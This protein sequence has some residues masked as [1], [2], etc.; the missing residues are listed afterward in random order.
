VE[1]RGGRP[2]LLRSPEVSRPT[3]SKFGDRRPSSTVRGEREREREQPQDME[4]KKSPFEAQRRTAPGGSERGV[5][6]P[7]ERLRAWAPLGRN[8]GEELLL[9]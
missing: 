6:E 4:R 2:C 8:L 5:R 7:S 1:A 9:C 3:G